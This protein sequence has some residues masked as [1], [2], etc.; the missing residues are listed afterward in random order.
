M[1]RRLRDRATDAWMSLEEPRWVTAC[2][3]V[4]YMI[5]VAI[6]VTTIVSP[7]NAIVHVWGGPLSTAWGL[8]MTTGGTLGALACSKGLWWLESRA[9]GLVMLGVMLRMILVFSLHVSSTGSRLVQLLELA[10]VLTSLLVRWLRIRDLPID[11]SR[12][13]ARADHPG[14]R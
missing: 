1:M 13:R 11:P 3:I 4:I 5:A 12:G 9:L 2:Q 8:L 6:G 14:H 10:L 7:P